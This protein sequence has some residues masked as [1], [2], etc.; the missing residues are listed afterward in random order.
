MEK[1]KII[2]NQVS[3]EEIVKLLDFATNRELDFECFEG[4]LI[5][6]YIIYNNNVIQIDNHPTTEFI[7]IKE[8]YLDYW[9]S[10]SDV[11][12]TDD[13]EL[14]ESYIEEFERDDV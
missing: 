11:I 3:S 14:L 5:D 8:K 12:L 6:N 4:T 13:E 2:I 1:E 10:T 9:D 7:I